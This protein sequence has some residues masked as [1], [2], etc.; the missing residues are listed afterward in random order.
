MY[1]PKCGAQNPDG[2]K[3]CGSCGAIMQ[4][5]PPNQGYSYASDDEQSQNQQ[6]QNPQP[7]NN[8]NQSPKIPFYKKTWFIVLM[9]IFLP[10][11]GIILMWW[12]KKPK[13]MVARVLITILLVLYIFLGGSSIS[14]D[15]SK[16]D[17]TSSTV[18][19]TTD[20]EENEISESGTATEVSPD[21]YKAQCQELN[22]NELMRNPDQYIGQKFKVTVQIFSAS[23]KWST[24]TYYKAYTDN[25]NGTYF[26]KM[27]WIFDKR[28]EDSD[29][30]V[31]ILE[32]DIVT[33]YGEFN[34][35]QETKNALNGEKGED[36][37]LDIYYADIV[38]E[39][40]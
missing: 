19:K 17:T 25:G 36:L 39:A 35:L 16:S 29:G 32:D 38:Q 14:S 20:G 9:C 7:Q 6:Q 11:I 4:T 2:Q 1:C 40:Q 5:F 34:G 31:K 18:T 15:D 33:F 37:A 3:F 27:I 12:H 28:T 23:E 30:Y 21:E 10:P 26:D 8:F 13:N 22:Y 24:G